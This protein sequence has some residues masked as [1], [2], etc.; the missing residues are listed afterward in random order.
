MLLKHFYN[1]KK[2]SPYKNKD[3]TVQNYVLATKNV[4]FQELLILFVG[5][6]L[7]I[8]VICL[9]N[10]T[11][12]SV[13][14]PFFNQNHE[15]HHKPTNDTLQPTHNN[16]IV[17]L[18]S[19][20]NRNHINTKCFYHLLCFFF[21]IK[22]EHV[23]FKIQLEQCHNNVVLRQQKTSKC[24]TNYTS[25]QKHCFSRNGAVRRWR[26]S[27]LGTVALLDSFSLHIKHNGVCRCIPGKS[28]S[29]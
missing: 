28:K 27:L 26:L 23:H 2:K 19:V 7:F 21:Q 8:C 20:L 1:F 17:V 15:A 13:F 24:F 4:T 11:L 22:S 16:N 3:K 29:K 9:N 25:V 12:I 6:I 18:L 5:M 14:Q 10:M